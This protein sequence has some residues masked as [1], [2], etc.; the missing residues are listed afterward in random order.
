MHTSRISTLPNTHTIRFNQFAIQIH[1]PAI[2]LLL[3]LA[4]NVSV[5]TFYIF[6]VLPFPN[7]RSHERT[8][9]E[10]ELVYEELLHIAALSHL[11]TSIKRELASIIVFEA[12]AHAGTVC[13]YIC[14]SAPYRETVTFYDSGKFGTGIGR[15]LIMSDLV[16]SAVKFY[17]CH[18]R[19]ALAHIM[20]DDEKEGENAPGCLPSGCARKEFAIS[21]RDWLHA[22][23]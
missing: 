19:S 10:L 8:H 7:G 3:S 4:L 13:K 17:D 5:L 22:A 2:F 23:F 18:P 14:S 11:S 9:E 12:H 21:H 6:F 1:N 20:A 15:C 16:S